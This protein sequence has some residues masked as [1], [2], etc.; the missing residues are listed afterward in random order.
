MANEQEERVSALADGELD[1]HQL[2]ALLARMREGDALR[3]RWARYHLISDA[4]HNNLTRNVQ[5]DISRRVSA[6]LEQEPVIFA[7]LWQRA[8]P[9]R[10]MVK[11]AASVAMAASVTAVA[12][13][14]AQWVNRDFPETAMPSVASIATPEGSRVELVALESPANGQPAPVVAQLAEGQQVESRPAQGQQLAEQVWIRNLDSYVVNHN[15]YSGS[16]GMYGV[17]PYARLVSHESQE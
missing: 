7:P 14:G 12:I 6:A 5:L 4:L 16:T 8:M 17:L 3:A 13:L 10:R 1:S 9:T 15:E 11:Q 2:D